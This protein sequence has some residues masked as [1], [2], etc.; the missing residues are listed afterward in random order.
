M[1]EHRYMNP[2]TPS[3]PQIDPQ[4][5]G[6]HGGHVVYAMP[7][8]LRLAA[9]DPLRTLDFFT[10]ALDFDVMFR[11]PD[12]GGVPVLVH[13]RRSKYQDVLVMPSRQAVQPAMAL[14]VSFTVADADA[15]DALAERIR[16]HAPETLAGPIDTPWNARELTVR[17]PDGN[18]FVFTARSRTPTAGSVDDIVRAAARRE[19]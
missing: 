18:A 15:L 13:L 19:P 4:T 5:L 11:G 2:N 17:D 10:R 3:H 7:M 12:A 14:S 16:R 8:F 6:E 9:G 1:P